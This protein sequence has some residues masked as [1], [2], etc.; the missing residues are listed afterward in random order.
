MNDYYFLKA[1]IEG[2]YYSAIGMIIAVVLIVLSPYETGFASRWPDG[3][4]TCSG[5]T[6]F[7]ATKHAVGH[8][9]HWVAYVTIAFVLWRLH[10]TKKLVRYSEI[11]INLVGLFILGCGFSHLL[12]FITIFW[13]IYPI[14]GYWLIINGILS[15]ISCLAVAYT[16]PEAFKAVREKEK[17]NEH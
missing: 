3:E 1:L 16:L 17:L 13:S 4:M 8:V 12:A 10:P 11:T 14:E 15:L 2:L 6:E 5:W 9:L 7:E